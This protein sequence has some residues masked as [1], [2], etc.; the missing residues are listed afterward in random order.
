MKSSRSRCAAL[1]REQTL[2]K[3]RLV[4]RVRFRNISFRKGFEKTVR[5]HGS[6]QMAESR[7]PCP[8]DTSTL[9]AASGRL[10]ET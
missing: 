3:L 7:R 9:V 4:R 10:T 1:V 5:A 6:S 2:C 8:P